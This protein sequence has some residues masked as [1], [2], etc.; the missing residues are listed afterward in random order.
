MSEE[1]G[2]KSGEALTPVSRVRVQVRADAFVYEGLVTLLPDS[3]RL[4]SVLNDPRPFLNMTDVDV[5]DAASGKTYSTAYLAL[6]KGAITH[7]IL[8][9]EGLQPATASPASGR[10]DPAFSSAPTASP[11]P[12][13]AVPTLPPQGPPTLPAPAPSP[14]VGRRTDSPTQPF[15]AL[16]DEVS[17]LI[18]DDDGDHE[19]DDIDPE[20]L[21]GASG[22]YKSRPVGE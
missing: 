20:D 13:V 21:L 7:V 3:E 9:S 11:M 5:F 8:V 1:G 18:L 15:R 19:K 17:D 12:V 2:E 14:R 10:A 22:E 16:D 4:Q 6:N